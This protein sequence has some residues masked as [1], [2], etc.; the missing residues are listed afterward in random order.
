MN[1]APHT[2]YLKTLMENPEVNKLLQKALSS[3]PLYEEVVKPNG[4]SYIPT[5][6]A[7]NEAILNHYKYREI[8]FETVGRFLDEFEI[9]MKEIMPYYN[10]LFKTVDTMNNIEDI[11]GNVDVTET[12]TETREGSSSGKVSGETTGTNE[13][14]N[15]SIATDNQNSNVDMSDNGKNIKSDTPQDDL[16]ITSED[17]D[18]VSYASEV[19]WNKNNSNSKTNSSGNS[20]AESESQSISKNITSGEN[21][22][23]ETTITTHTFNKKGNQGVN[24]YAH[25]MIEFRNTILNVVQQII[26]D[27]RISELFLMIY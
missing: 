14:S 21:E 26:N 12:F 18:S 20:T 4:I 3:Y 9:S 13:A 7:L 27:S 1:N 17:I 5:R 22:S 2:V 16:S 23:T 24:T 15:T 11:F 19:N 8:G 25:D 6:E 10:Q